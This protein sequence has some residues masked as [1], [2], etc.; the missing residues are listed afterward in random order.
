MK[1][2]AAGPAPRRPANRLATE[3]DPN[4]ARRAEILARRRATSRDPELIALA[5]DVID[6]PPT[7]DAGYKMFKVPETPQS[8]EV[9]QLL[10]RMASD[11]YTSCC[12]HELLH[13]RLC[14]NKCNK[15]PSCR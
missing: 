14:L 13:W 9:D 11:S 12:R 10:Q 2:A 8:I 15:K 3:Y 7:N 6:A 5:R 4:I 1:A